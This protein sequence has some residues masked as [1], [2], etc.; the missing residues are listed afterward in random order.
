[1]RGFPPPLL[2]TYAQRQGQY[3]CLVWGRSELRPYHPGTEQPQEVAPAVRTRRGTAYRAPAPPSRDKVLP[4]RPVCTHCGETACLLSSN[5]E[6]RL[7]YDHPAFRTRE[8]TEY[9]FRGRPAA[10]CREEC[11]S[12]PVERTGTLF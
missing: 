11:V 2:G 6:L 12:R 5:C 7:A 9:T 3:T 1:M 10:S 8:V 4:M